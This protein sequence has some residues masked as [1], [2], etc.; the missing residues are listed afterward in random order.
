MPAKRNYFKTI[1]GLAYYSIA[2]KYAGRRRIG[3]NKPGRY[4]GNF[5]HKKWNRKNKI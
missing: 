4:L 3:N 5:Y 1:P 2:F